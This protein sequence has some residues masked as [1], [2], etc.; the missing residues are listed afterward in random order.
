MSRYFDGLVAHLAPPSSVRPGALRP[1]V[2][3]R[4]ESVRPDGA[5]FDLAEAAGFEAAGLEGGVPIT[6]AAPPARGRTSAHAAPPSSPHEH[7]LRAPL[8]DAPARWGGDPEVASP[9]Q[10][11][12]RTEDRIPRPAVAQAVFDETPAPLPG[13]ASADPPRPV[14]AAPDAAPA[15]L[16]PA[17]RDPPRRVEP[18]APRRPAEPASPAREAPVETVIEIH[19][20]RVEVRAPA[21]PP[22]SLRPTARPA[23]GGGLEDYLE[24][25][26]RR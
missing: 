8:V 17:R 13:V 19:I 1:A 18:L 26:R 4:F 20:G 3:S 15:R 10:N 25:R 16:E 14:D 9:K 21:A 7:P 23:G 22:R 24:A 11:P 2:A 5:A 12:A 6:A